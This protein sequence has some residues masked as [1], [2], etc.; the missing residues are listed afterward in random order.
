MATANLI[1]IKDEQASQNRARAAIESYSPRSDE[2]R[3][4]LEPIPVRKGK[5]LDVDEVLARSFARVVGE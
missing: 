4:R 1:L 2:Q 3:L 5:H